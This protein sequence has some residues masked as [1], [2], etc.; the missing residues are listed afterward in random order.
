MAC[1]ATHS[2]AARG[3]FSMDRSMAKSGCHNRC[4]SLSPLSLLT[5]ATKK[6]IERGASSLLG[7]IRLRRGRGAGEIKKN[8]I[9]ERECGSSKGYATIFILFTCLHLRTY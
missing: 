3:G 5:L 6:K 8:E 1:E 9:S 2:T 7:S 4:I